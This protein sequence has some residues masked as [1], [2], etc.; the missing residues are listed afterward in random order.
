[1][2]KNLLRHIN[3]E[4]NLACS[5]Q[6]F[7][8]LSIIMGSKYERNEIIQKEILNVTIT[9]IK[10]SARMFDQFRDKSQ[11][12]KALRDRIMMIADEMDF[13]GREKS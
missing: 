11:D 13:G 4:Y 9:S 5:K 8:I 10:D 6:I 12:R 7:E 3:V 1:V 2:V